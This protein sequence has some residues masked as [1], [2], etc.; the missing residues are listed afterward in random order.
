MATASATV[1]PVALAASASAMSKRKRMNNLN[2]IT[3]MS[4]FGGLKAH[5]TVA[6][7]GVPLCTEP[8]F[9]NIV[10]SL[11]SQGQGRGGGA[12][13]SKCNAVG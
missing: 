11:R 9:A 1:A 10:S 3:G 2:Y 6:S 7:L 8:S 4:A 13:S 12:L 5:N